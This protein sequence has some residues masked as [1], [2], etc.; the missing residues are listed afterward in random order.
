[1]RAA[2][3]GRLRSKFWVFTSQVSSSVSE[4]T[5]VRDRLHTKIEGDLV[6]VPRHSLPGFFSKFLLVPVAHSSSRDTRGVP[7]LTSHDTEHRQVDGRPQS[8]RASVLF[9]AH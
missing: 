6:D 2:T 1:M 4:V 9:F 5:R 8:G 3:G 7:K